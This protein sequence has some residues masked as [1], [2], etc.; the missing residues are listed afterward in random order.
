MTSYN[1]KGEEIFIEVKSTKGRVIN[2]LEITDTEW[3]AAIDNKEKYFI[4]L[5]N[6]ALDDDIMI[7]DRIKNPALLVDKNIIT[8]ETSVYH[9]ELYKN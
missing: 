4:Y 3:K 8:I 1:E 6:R 9:L 5:V 7:I 2:S